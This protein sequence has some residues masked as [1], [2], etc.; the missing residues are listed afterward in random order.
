MAIQ[1]IPVAGARV[2]GDLQ[3]KGTGRMKIK[4][5]FFSMQWTI[6]LGFMG[7]VTVVGVVV[8][9]AFL[10]GAEQRQKSFTWRML[11]QN[12]EAANKEHERL[13]LPVKSMLF[14]LQ[15]WGR[16]DLL[17]LNGSESIDSLNKML[18]PLLEEINHI[19]SLVIADETGASYV[20]S[21][22]ED[23]YYEG[24]INRF[25]SPEKSPGEALVIRWNRDFSRS[26]RSIES[27]DFDARKR[28]WF[29]EAMEAPTR[30]VSWTG[31]YRFII[32]D[33]YGV[34]ASTRWEDEN[35]RTWVVAV[36][37]LLDDISAFT[38]QMRV[39]KRGY[40]VVM[41]SRK[42]VIGLPWPAVNRFN[43][44][45]S[46]ATIKESSSNPLSTTSLYKDAVP[47]PSLEAALDQWD[48]RIQSSFDQIR[49]RVDDEFWLAGFSPFV[50]S[51]KRIFWIG[52]IVPEKEI[53]EP[54]ATV[55]R[56]L[57]YAGI[58]ALFLA[59][60]ASIRLARSYSSA[61]GTLAEN[62]RRIGAFQFDQIEPVNA[63][64]VEIEVLARSQRR[65]TGVLKSFSSYVPMNL[66]RKLLR[67]REMATITGHE[68]EITVFF[69]DVVGFSSIA[70]EMEPEALALHMADYFET[71]VQCLRHYEATIDK[72]IG[73]AV[74]AFWG[75]PVEDPDQVI[76]A[77]EALCE[78]MERIK[79]R[80][81]E[82]EAKGLPV[83]KTRF[84]LHHGTAVVGN[85]GSPKRI[86]YTALGDVVD[87]ALKMEELNQEFGSE[88]IVS[89]A[90]RRMVGDRYE[91]KDIGE[92]ALLKGKP[93]VHC[94]IFL[95]RRMA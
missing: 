79:Q 89:D 88:V 75:A 31:P 30:S 9:L 8:F 87:Q 20:L 48:S 34:T 3:P 65:M 81:V 16:N 42:T 61:L 22:R 43:N 71:I 82:W 60:T 2:Y 63:R 19:S 25:T 44:G 50:L 83:I 56:Q 53:L 55:R 15:H 86:A 26:T 70:E 11:N 35:G 77:L 37:M 17:E 95:G 27:M 64:I 47:I 28:P 78:C 54:A 91:F 36:D 59:L 38:S 12:L 80:Q 51:P 94:H 14:T 85:V 39:G 69:S 74:L 33:E 29:I 24:W 10:A 67:H 45:F 41:D 57:Y 52:I 68:A 66:V 84:G 5:G 72:L 4:P 58:G 93:K 62:S 7:L 32:G 6:L 92:I 1:H 90:V 73:D 76:H 40:A 46:N 49:F 23:F 18:S 21:R 13:F